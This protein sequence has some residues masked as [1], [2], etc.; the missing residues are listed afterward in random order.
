MDLLLGIISQLICVTVPKTGGYKTK[1][2][3]IAAGMSASVFTQI[4]L[5]V[6][7][8]HLS[9]LSLAIC[10]LS[11]SMILIWVAVIIKHNLI[12]YELGIQYIYYENTAYQ[13]S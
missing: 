11:L 1:I 13:P 4:A 12:K 7:L 10:I 5:L 2:H 8:T 3:L 9:P 6:F